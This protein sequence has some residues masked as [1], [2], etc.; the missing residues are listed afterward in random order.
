MILRNFN[1]KGYLRFIIIVPAAIISL[2]A[3]NS[4]LSIN[5]LLLTVVQKIR[6]F[7]NLIVLKEALLHV[8]L[9]NIHDMPSRGHP[10]IDYDKSKA[11]LFL[12]LYLEMS[13]MTSLHYTRCFFFNKS[14]STNWK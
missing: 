11:C 4:K 13:I 5:F 7:V 10:K 8:A 3:T 14:I 2:R 9:I 12:H 1:L 6:H